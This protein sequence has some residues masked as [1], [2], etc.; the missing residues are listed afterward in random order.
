MAV[1]SIDTETRSQIWT[2]KKFPIKIRKFLQILIYHTTLKVYWTAKE[3]Y[4]SLALQNKSFEAIS[5][6][7][8][9][10]K[11]YTIDPLH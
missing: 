3:S 5:L 6:Q 7:L 10:R 11:I 1:K 4:H 9:F 2:I 8:K